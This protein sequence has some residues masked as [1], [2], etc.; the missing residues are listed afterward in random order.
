MSPT[1]NTI[2]GIIQKRRMT[3][4]I[5]SIITP[6]LN[7]GKYIRQCVDS[8]LAQNYTNTEHI[9]IDGQST[10]NTLDIIRE[11]QH[12]KWISEPDKGE[13][14]ALNKGVERASGDLICWLNGDDWLDES[15]FTSVIENL[16]NDD[17]ILY[18]NT[19]IYDHKDN[20]FW[21]KKS[22]RNI[23]LKFLLKWFQAGI[24]PHQPSMFIRKN[25]FQTIGEF[26]QHLN[27]S[28]DLEFWIRAAQHYSFKYVNNVLSNARLRKDSKSWDTEKEQIESHWTVVKPYLEKLNCNDRENFW[29]E[30]FTT[31]T[32]FCYLDDKVYPLIKSY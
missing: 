18:G 28:I 32:Y 22:N 29:Y 5:I 10:D 19:N 21:V 2:H 27:Y 13:V 3:K 25:V 12:L 17:F 15:A 20:L 4:P 8:V 24:H 16:T 6:T 7:C 23:N 9:I 30:Y 1:N 11:Y 26:N 31:S 14:E